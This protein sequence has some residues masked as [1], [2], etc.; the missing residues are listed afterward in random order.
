VD[1]K[2]K[3]LIARRLLEGVSAST[4]AAEYGLTKD[5][6]YFI[7]KAYKD[8]LGTPPAVH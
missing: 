4:L 8:K 6:L 2:T 3:E 7:I 1:A 5:A